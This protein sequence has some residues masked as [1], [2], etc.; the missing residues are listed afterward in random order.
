[1]RNG[2]S[3]AFVLHLVQPSA[4]PATNHFGDLVSLCGWH[5]ALIQYGQWA[6]LD[7]DTK[8]D[9]QDPERLKEVLLSATPLTDEQDNDYVG[10]PVKFWNVYEARDSKPTMVEEEIRYSLPHWKYLGELLTVEEDR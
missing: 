7:P 2:D 1:M 4:H 8:D 9:I 6:F 10:L 5:Y 3:Q